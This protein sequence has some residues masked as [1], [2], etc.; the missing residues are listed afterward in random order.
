MLLHTVPHWLRVFGERLR[1]V[2]IVVDD[3]PPVGRIGKLHHGHACKAQLFEAVDAL[4]HLDDRV[5]FLR[6]GD[7]N[8]EATQQRW[9]GSARPVRC[10]AG[11]PILPF[12]AAVDAALEDFVLRCDSDMLFV[13]HGW[14]DEGIERLKRGTHVYEPP[15]LHLE[16]SPRASSRA[17]LIQRSS[18]YDRLP[19]RHLCLDPARSIHRIITGRPIWIALEEMLERSSANGDLVHQ[20]GKDTDLGFSLHA[21]RRTYA[22]SCQFG[23]I[24][25]SVENGRVPEA[26]WQSWDLNPA[27]WG[28]NANP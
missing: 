8:I 19:L 2:V 14:L 26:Q 13:E 9:F 25:A 21:W 10:Q 12:A 15:R 20:I 3:Q 18:L 1:E 16:I 7:L 6:L 23:D 5:R 4:T 27:A 17:F 24:V 11:T 28:V 22:E